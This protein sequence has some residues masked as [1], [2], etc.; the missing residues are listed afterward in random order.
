MQ[1]DG[2]SY[3]DTGVECA[4]DGRDPSRIAYQVCINVLSTGVS[5]DY[6][7][8]SVKKFA[9]SAYTP[10]DTHYETFYS[11]SEDALSCT[12]HFYNAL[13]GVQP[14][15]LSGSTE[16][17]LV[18]NPLV[19]FADNAKTDSLQFT[20]G[21]PSSSKSAGAKGVE[22]SKLKFNTFYSFYKPA[23]KDIAIVNSLST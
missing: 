20:F 11:E 5:S 23:S 21:H 7:V 10:D 19:V 14:Y 13:F 2:K 1:S 3:I 9:P 6:N 17:P 4:G 22:F 16:H 8:D 15:K 18:N 12:T